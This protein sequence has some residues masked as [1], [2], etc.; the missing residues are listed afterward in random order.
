MRNAN[1]TLRT[2][3]RVTVVAA[4]LLVTLI[5]VA[6]PAAA[7]PISPGSSVY[8][9]GSTG[10]DVAWPNCTATPPTRPAFGIVGVND[11]TGYSQSPCLAKQAG[12]FSNLSLY[13]NTGWYNQSS[14]VNPS[15][16]KVCATGDNNCLAYNYGYNAGLYALNYANS[17]SVHASVWW[18]DVENGNTWNAD[19]TQNRNSLQ[20]EYDALHANGVATVGVYSTTYQWNTITGTWLNKW[21]NWGATT[22]S[23]ARKAAAFCTG[24]QFT[25]G[26][27]YLI[28]FTGS[29]DQDY[30][31]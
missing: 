20:G 19:T 22:V 14:H 13:V 21:P 2:L 6:R 10:Y 28:Q 1:K 23:S 9:S 16:P 25:G 31:C 18:L 3:G 29:L 17:Q 27:T 8:P 15:S 11:G 7:A 5:V 24:H 30:A 26:P 12:W 4:A